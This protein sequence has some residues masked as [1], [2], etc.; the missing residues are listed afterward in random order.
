M[1]Q[2]QPI[3][4]ALERASADLD[5]IIQELR[6]GRRTVAQLH[7]LEERAQAL[8]GDVVGAFRGEAAATRTKLG[9]SG[10]IWAF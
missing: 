2:P 10:G 6:L 9:R 7:D 1:A 4:D 8:A 3:A 5:T